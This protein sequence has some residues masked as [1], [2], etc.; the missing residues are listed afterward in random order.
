MAEP[1]RKYKQMGDQM[2]I[3]EWEARQGRMQAALAG[4]EGLT[5]EDCLEFFENKATARDEAISDMAPANG[6]EF[7]VQ[8]SIISEH[9][10]NGAYVLG[11]RWVDFVCTQFDKTTEQGKL[12]FESVAI[13]QAV[14][15]NTISPGDLKS[16][17]IKAGMP[18]HVFPPDE[19]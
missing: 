15:N 9:G 5:L 8:G 7:A 18:P 1:G 12:S 2:N 17:L 19:G 6:L 4:I 11:W 14:R 10:G 3:D 16:F 13:W